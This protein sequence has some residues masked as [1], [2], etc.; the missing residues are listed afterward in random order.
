MRLALLVVA[1]LVATEASAAACPAMA[2]ADRV[3]TPD[4]ADVY[5]GGGVIMIAETGMGNLRNDEVVAGGTKLRAS[6]YIAAGL[7][8]YAPPADATEI[9]VQ[10]GGKIV[11]KLAVVAG[12]AVLAA[13]KL[14][15]VTSS[16]TKQ[17]PARFTRTMSIPSTT[18]TVTLAAPPPDDAFALVAYDRRGNDAQP[19]AWMLVD[20]STTTFTIHT[21]GKACARG[22]ANPTF[23]G[24]HLRFVWLDRGGRLSKT[25]SMLRVGKTR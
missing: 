11:R 2:I 25:T 20:S 21:G 17:S 15:A 10:A 6:R 5:A 1:A 23:I 9:E 7:S 4:G 12:P 8:V 14:K 19:R 13:P 3:A 16:A 22:T 18:M 24:D